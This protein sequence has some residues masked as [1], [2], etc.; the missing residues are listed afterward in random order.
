MNAYQREVDACTREEHER[1]SRRIAAWLRTH[2]ST[3]HAEHYAWEWRTIEAARR[4]GEVHA[5]QT[6]FALGSHT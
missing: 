3:S 4:E 6:R 1:A 2:K 5:A